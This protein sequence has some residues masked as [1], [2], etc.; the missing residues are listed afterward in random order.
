MAKSIMGGMTDYRHQSF[1]D[2]LSEINNEERQT[3]AFRDAIL[4]NIED[5]QRSSYWEKNVESNFVSIINYSLLFYKTTIDELSSLSKELR[6]E[7]KDY[8]VNQ[9]K[10]IG[11]VAGE[12]NFDIGKIWHNYYLRKDYGE[13]N[14]RKVEN[15][16]ADARDLAVRLQD[17]SNMA[18][19]LNDFIGKTPLHMKKNNPWIAGSFYLTTTVTLVILLAIISNLIPWWALPIVIIGGI[20]LIIIVGILQLKNDGKVSEMAF[21]EIVKE[22]F[23]QLPLLK[24]DNR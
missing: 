4:K 19:R 16:Y 24:K 13:E 14:F 8:H 22:T 17:M 3:I 15:I 2:I 12:L 10:N 23:K 18:E 1:S 6:I 11:K 21:L 20:L 5:L 9:L 7:V